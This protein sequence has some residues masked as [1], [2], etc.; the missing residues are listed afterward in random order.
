MINDGLIKKENIILPDFS[1]NNVW[2]DYFNKIKHI[3][4][5]L[6]WV[7]QDGHVCSLFPWHKILKD[8]S[9]TYINIYDS[10]KPP[11][12]R[13]TITKNILKQIN[14]WFVFFIWDSKKDALNKFLDQKIDYTG[15]PVKLIINCK[16]SFLISDIEKSF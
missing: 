13:I 4:I 14:F 5:W 1:L 3:D 8:E 11:K 7:G 15:C 9:I 6:F 2:Q 16:K 12:N 10:P